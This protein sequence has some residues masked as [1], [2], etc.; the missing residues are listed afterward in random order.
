MLKFVHL[1][2]A[3]TLIMVG[4]VV[5]ESPVP[6]EKVATVADLELEV[7]G[8]IETLEKL[9]GEEAKFED[10]EKAI[11]QA[12]GVLACMGQ[13][14]AEHPG[15]KET[16]VQGPQLRDAALS[17]AEEESF[18]SATKALGVLKQAQAGE[19]KT[20]SKVEH[21][22][23][24]LIEMYPLMEEMN[25]RNAKLV[26]VM[27]RPRGKPDESLHATTL[28]VLA[29]AMLADTSPVF[30]DADIPK[31]QGWSNEY[32]ENMMKVADAVRAKDGT[33]A[34]QWFDK[35]NIACDQCHAEIRD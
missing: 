15:N 32:R 26:R 27:K 6:I 25:T 30:D 20:E 8:Q 13:A 29:I 11:H 3:A 24:E 21:A 33:T 10:N 14:I 35:A 12:I 2:T 5:A 4:S 23:D 31:W 19:C 34:R 7:A 16:K 18:Q 9:L 17:Y 22:W 1:L 28:A